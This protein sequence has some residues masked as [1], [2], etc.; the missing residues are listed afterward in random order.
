MIEAKKNSMCFSFGAKVECNIL[1]VIFLAGRRRQ[2]MNLFMCLPCI[3]ES[4]QEKLKGG[5][6][7]E[8]FEK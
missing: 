7:D 5:F 3:R 8:I 6:V 2:C 1:F 4:E